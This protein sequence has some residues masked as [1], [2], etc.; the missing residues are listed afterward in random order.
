MYQFQEHLTWILSDFLGREWRNAGIRPIASKFE[1]PTT[2]FITA[3]TLDGNPRMA[4]GSYF[5]SH[6]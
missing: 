2:P 4:V 5:L 1:K 6:A 3:F